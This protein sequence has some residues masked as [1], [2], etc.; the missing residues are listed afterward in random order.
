MHNFGRGRLGQRQRR[1][2]D[3]E[4]PVRR[5]VGHEDRGLAV[6]CAAARGL[7]V[8]RHH[9]H[10]ALVA[11]GRRRRL[12]RVDA[13]V[14]AGEE[15]AVQGQAQAVG[16]RQILRQGP[17]ALQLRRGRGIA[18]AAAAAAG[19]ARHL[20]GLH[21]RADRLALFLIGPEDVEIVRGDAA[22]RTHGAALGGA[23]TAAVARP[24]L[25]MR[26]RGLCVS[27]QHLLGGDLEHLALLLIGEVDI[28]K[29]INGDPT[30]FHVLRH[31]R[32]LVHAQGAVLADQKP[33]GD[34]LLE[35]GV[36]D[37]QQLP[38]LVH[39][40]ALGV[41]QLLVDQDP[42]WAVPSS[43]GELD[44]TDRAVP[45]V[46]HDEVLCRRD[47]AARAELHSRRQKQQRQL[48]AEHA[49]AAPS[50]AGGAPRKS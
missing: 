20:Q 40:D 33:V 45:S 37:E 34:H 42:H 12:H 50:E 9:R 1:G 25:R 31:W 46:G 6:P 43:P 30:R 14:R 7:Q 48:Y 4:D 18:S 19:P 13:L 10:H 29:A 16:L 8:G 23:E 49:A 41:D 3:R 27:V 17:R 2:R 11:R 32:L 26:R 35:L 24:S 44:V 36:R 47:V 21:H 22:R 38:L 15:E 5:S 39:G 28:A